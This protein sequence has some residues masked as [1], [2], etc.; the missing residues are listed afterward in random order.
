MGENATQGNTL[1]RLND[2]LF[3]ELDR[4]GAVDA[5]DADA[6]RAEIDRAKSIE[7]VSRT[8]VDNAKVIIDAT[9]MRANLTH[10]VRTPKMLEG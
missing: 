10:E 7:G 5:S 4:L 6:L 2:E 9:I 1:G 3:A 8:I